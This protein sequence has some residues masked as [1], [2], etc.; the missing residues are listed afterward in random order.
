[1]LGV[2]VVFS[3]AKSKTI[4]ANFA[5]FEKILYLQFVHIFGIVAVSIRLAFIVV[6]IPSASRNGAVVAIL[7]G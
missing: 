5:I 2:Y 3:L 7:I 4:G 6:W 1:L